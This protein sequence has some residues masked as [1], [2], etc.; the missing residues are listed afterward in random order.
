MKRRIRATEQGDIVKNR[1]YSAQEYL[2]R[3]VFCVNCHGYRQCYPEC[4]NPDVH[5]INTL[6][7]VPAKNAPKKKWDLFI[8]R[9]TS[10]N[11]K[12]LYGIKNYKTSAPYSEHRKQQ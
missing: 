2:H 3:V 12:N 8:K 6:A 1:R 9:Y 5:L 10:N 11:T 4:N 7:Q